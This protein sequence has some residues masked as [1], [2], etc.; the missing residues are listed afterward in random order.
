MKEELIKY[1]MEK[2]NKQYSDDFPILHIEVWIREFFDYYQ[3]ERLNP[4]TPKGDAIV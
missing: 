4:E 2:A 1:V 3:P